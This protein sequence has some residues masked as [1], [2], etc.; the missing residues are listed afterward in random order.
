MVN[1]NNLQK[2][3]D[4]VARQVVYLSEEKKLSTEAA[5]GLIA[6]EASD[7]VKAAVAVFG[8]ILAGD[9]LDL[10]KASPFYTFTENICD[11]N[12]SP[13][14]VGMLLTKFIKLHK[15]YSQ[16]VRSYLLSLK[17]TFAYSGALITIAFMI[18]LLYNQYVLSGINSFFAEY[19][20]ELPAFTAYMMSGGMYVIY[21]V[22]LISA[23]FI[24]SFALTI[25][26]I[27]KETG[28]FKP[29]S[30]WITRFY[31][32]N[33]I[34]MAVNRYL[35]LNYISLLLNNDD[36]K[37]RAIDRAVELVTGRSADEKGSMFHPGF[38]EELRLVSKIGVLGNEIEYLLENASDELQHQIINFRSKVNIGF[39]IM[40]FVVIG[41]LVIAYYLPLFNI[42]SMI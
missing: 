2:S 36:F 20:G 42:A 21:G 29:V 12:A 32:S 39:Q 11:K 33:G 22:L 23:L 24:I 4:F 30:S 27:L 17:S 37:E 40:I 31:V 8:R 15:E 7:E 19:G 18:S 41:A 35:L 14:S 28:S 6:A 34:T 5:L 25:K 10:G 3:M 13:G 16:V 1:D 26:K 9:K 38:V